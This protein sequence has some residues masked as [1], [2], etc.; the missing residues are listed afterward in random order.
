MKKL[1]NTEAGL[2]KTVALK[3]VYILVNKGINKGINK[4]TQ[5]LFSLYEELF[6]RINFE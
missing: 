6:L 1:S 3:K 2:K 5:H 4:G